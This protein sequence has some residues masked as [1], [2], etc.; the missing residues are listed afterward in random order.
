MSR[1]DPPPAAR[2]L[3]EKL[4]FGSASDSLAGDLLEEFRSGRSLS[5]YW[6]QVLAAIL[7]SG[8]RELRGRRSIFGFALLW[9]ALT[10]ALYLNYSRFLSHSSFLDKLW[11]LPWPWSTICAMAVY[12]G[13]DLLVL[14]I[15]M[16]L[17]LSLHFCI[18]RELGFPRLGRGLLVSLVFYVLLMLAVVVMPNRGSGI[19][20]RTATVTSLLCDPY[21]M[22]LRIPGLLSLIL[23]TW[24]ALPRSRP[25][26]VQVAQIN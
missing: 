25:H 11:S 18:K 1:G 9:S 6:R 21:F 4:T 19:D 5:W 3:M 24:V 8:L 16:A 12:L 20:L 26:S 22:L 23:A 13:P 15:G 7:V 2:W 17:Y 14:W 10:P